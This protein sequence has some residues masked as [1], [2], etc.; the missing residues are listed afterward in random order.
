MFAKSR[1]PNLPRPREHM[2]ELCPPS[3]SRC[4]LLLV[5]LA[6]ANAFGGLSDD[7][8]LHA[9]PLFRKP[10]VSTGQLEL[11]EDG[12][13]VLRAQTE[14]FAIVSAVGPTRTGKSSILGRSFFRGE[15]E[16]IFESGSGVTS[17]TGGVWIA[18]QP[19]TMQLADGSSLRVL[20]IDT[21]GFSGVGGITSKTYEANLFGLVYLLSSVVI[22]NTMFPVDASTVASLNAHASHALSML[23]ALTDSGQA[24][25]KS[26]PRLVWAIQSFN[27]FNLHN[28]GM[29]AEDLL[30]ALRNASR[31]TGQEHALAV[32]GD[33]ASNSAWLVEKLFEEQE[34][35]TVR[36]PHPS[37]EIVANLAKYNSSLLSADYLHDADQLQLATKHNL[38]PV[39][40]CKED[41]TILTITKC[42]AEPLVGADFVKQL[43]L[44]LKH[45]FILDRSDLEVD[46]ASETETLNNLRERNRVWFDSQCKSLNEEL[47]TKFY[48]YRDDSTMNQGLRQEAVAAVEKM[49]KGFHGAALSKL[50]E[51]GVFWKF[52]GKGAMLV[53]AQA[54]Q[55]M[56]RCK[57]TLDGTRRHM[58]DWVAQ[59]GK[60]EKLP[61]E[62]QKEA[63]SIAKKGLYQLVATDSSCFSRTD[64]HRI[65]LG[66]RF[67]LAS[68]AEAVSQKCECGRG[69]EFHEGNDGYC[70]CGTAGTPNSDCT[71]HQEDFT[72]GNSRYV[73][74]NPACMDEKRGRAMAEAAASAE[75]HSTGDGDHDGTVSASSVDKSPAAYAPTPQKA[76]RV[77]FDVYD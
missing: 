58:E 21:E 36:R 75:S 59:R 63:D 52:P 66:S 48:W 13:N 67:T 8:G 29:A 9:V 44:W 2:A 60:G 73:M 43:A 33:A 51:S 37:D 4:G 46:Y 12:L 23:Q 15:H 54:E 55:A 22:F 53:E 1:R 20:F 72:Y 64:A 3:R 27:I 7:L 39:H 24:V 57:E 70:G 42:T 28:S 47:R 69:F 14:P 45:G 68:C 30:A 31:A 6:V 35:V 17:H 11:V 65:S 38:K 40:R 10:A 74:Y 77:C 5:C 76:R 56:Q 19:I 49:M 50:V 71:E 34:L 41:G 16:N 26:K 61:Q 62:L 25:Q 18:S 32:L